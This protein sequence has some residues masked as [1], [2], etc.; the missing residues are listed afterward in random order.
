MTLEQ[1]CEFVKRFCRIIGIG[2]VEIHDA[3]EYHVHWYIRFGYSYIRDGSYNEDG[4]NSGQRTNVL[5][6]AAVDKRFGDVYFP[7]SRSKKRAVSSDFQSI[8]EIWVKSTKEDL[9]RFEREKAS[10]NS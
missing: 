4:S 1:A 6:Q 9:V 10:W 3:T 5:L 7:P 2:E 8:Q